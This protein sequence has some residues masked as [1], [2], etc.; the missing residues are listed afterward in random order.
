MMSS[1][2]T[3][4]TVMPLA[5]GVKRVA[6]MMGVSDRHVWKEIKAGRLKTVRSGRRV[7]ITLESL[8]AYLGLDSTSHKKSAKGG[9]E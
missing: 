2:D 8:S 6:K 7:L 3:P 9:C 1:V 4:E 5:S